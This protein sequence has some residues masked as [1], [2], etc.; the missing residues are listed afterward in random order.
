MP[1]TKTVLSDDTRENLKKAILDGKT[2]REIT[3]DLGVSRTTVIYYADKLGVK[4]T[5][6]KRRAIVDADE[7][8]K[9]YN[10]GLT[11]TEIAEKLGVNLCNVNDGIRR[12][13][14]AGRIG[15]RKHLRDRDALANNVVANVVLLCCEGNSYKN[16][17]VATKLPEKTIKK[18]IDDYVAF[19]NNLLDTN[20]LPRMMD[21]KMLNQITELYLKKVTIS[22]IQKDIGISAGSLTVY[23]NKLDEFISHGIESR[24]L[25][26][27]DK[28][29]DTTSIMQKPEPVKS[30]KS[31]NHKQRVTIL[32]L[33][34]GSSLEIRNYPDALID[35]LKKVTDGSLSVN[36]V[37]TIGSI[38]N[39]STT[40]TYVLSKE[41]K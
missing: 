38:L 4:L 36:D 9:L 35:L 37:I 8:F 32:K 26:H 25:L 14:K 10:E 16:I 13:S 34:D 19:K 3:E 12:L 31:D 39:E 40:T 33:S 29:T 7:L 5:K 1:T 15:K 22:N 11:Y 28:K 23:L 41:E 6:G 24:S 17:Y 21:S 20:S 18:I 30:V 27:E 2:A